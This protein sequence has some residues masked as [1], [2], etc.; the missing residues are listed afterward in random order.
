MVLARG[1]VDEPTQV[2]RRPMIVQAVVIERTRT[3]VA[4]DS[5]VDR[6]DF[7]TLVD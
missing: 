6:P 5:A 1:V 7:W 2:G 4:V 3:G